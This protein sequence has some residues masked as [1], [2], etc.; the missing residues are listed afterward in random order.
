MARSAQASV[1]ITDVRDGVA[2]KEVELYKIDS[3]STPPTG[4]GFNVN[5]GAAADAAT[6][7]TAVAPTVTVNQLLYRAVRGVQLDAGATL[8]TANPSEDWV[9][10]LASG[11]RGQIGSAGAAIAFDVD[12]NLDSDADKYELI[13]SYRGDNAVNN[14]DIYWQV[15]TGQVFQWQNPS[16]TDPTIPAGQSF[17]DLTTLQGGFLDINGITEVAFSP[18]AD[19]NIGIGEGAV[20]SI[21][22]SST[23]ATNNIGIGYNTLTSSSLN[24]ANNVALGYN[25]ISAVSTGA[26][27]IGIG[28]Y[29]GWRITSGANN[30]AMGNLTLGGLYSQNTG[31]D[32]TAIGNSSLVSHQYGDNNIAVG[33]SS[34]SGLTAGSYNLVLGAY[35]T[36]GRWGNFNIQLGGGYATN[37]GERTSSS[38]V[39][40]G[41]TQEAVWIADQI[42]T[43]SIAKNIIIGVDSAD[44]LPGYARNPLGTDDGILTNGNMGSGSTPSTSNWTNFTTNGAAPMSGVNVSSLTSGGQSENYLQIIT[45]NGSDAGAY[46]TVTTIVGK[47]YTVSG[48]FRRPVDPRSS[49]FP[50]GRI[51]K[52]NSVSDIS[53]SSS[54]SYVASTNTLT[55][56]QPNDKSELSFSF[57]ATAT[58]TYIALVGVA[59]GYYQWGNISVAQVGARNV[60]LGDTVAND[61]ELGDDNVLM[62]SR[63]GSALTSGSGNVCIGIEA[64]RNITTGSDN[65]AIG[66]NANGPSSGS[67]NITIGKSTFVPLN[68]AI[69]NTTS[70]GNSD[71]DR[72]TL[73]GRD[74]LTVQY[75]STVTPTTITQYGDQLII[76][77]TGFVPKGRKYLISFSLVS[78]ASSAI[79]CKLRRQVGTGSI[80]LIGQIETTVAGTNSVYSYEVQDVVAEYTDNVVYSVTA[81]ADST[82]G[83]PTNST[84]QLTIKKVG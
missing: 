32:N 57:V 43:D 23:L 21:Q 46:Q 64:G 41:S 83:L 74:A 67:N 51:V 6:G 18:G 60:L 54:S 26:S 61:L 56:G 80:E 42:K 8:W 25:A 24:A 3:P 73:N 52:A 48:T 79:N 31:S 12:A 45:S 19:G 35:T 75:S 4:L 9:I 16:T 20:D 14:A 44:T 17:T 29:A 81:R 53:N 82:I 63:V 5:T 27:N 70:I 72:L 15:T 62:G 2:F 58:T 28:S 78:T 38:F 7:W 1:T 66:S 40:G 59:Y 84:F 30:I 11:I 10:S 77:A 68:T 69:S 22:A 34:A 39:V 76:A 13:Q 55:F 37:F 49:S 33:R 50:I 71:A 47:T 65:I 36:A